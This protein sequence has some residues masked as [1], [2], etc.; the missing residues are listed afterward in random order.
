[1]E[2]NRQMLREL[3]EV[4]VGGENGEIAARGDGA[5]QKIGIRAPEFPRRDSD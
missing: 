3:R 5:D 1:M 2:N 4:L